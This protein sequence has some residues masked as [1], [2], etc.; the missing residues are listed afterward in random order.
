MEVMEVLA[1]EGGAAPRWTGGRRRKARLK[2]AQVLT[3]TDT[4]RVLGV[5][6]G[7]EL[8]DSNT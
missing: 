7:A 5:G 4:L 3:T 6:R 2:S 1:K 8:H